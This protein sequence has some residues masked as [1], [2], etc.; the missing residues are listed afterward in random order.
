[1]I[2]NT[3]KVH[4]KI[5]APLKK[6]KQKKKKNMYLPTDEYFALDILCMFNAIKLLYCILYCILR[7]D[8]NNRLKTFK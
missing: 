3:K 4:I 8:C 7:H 5:Q 2:D 6:Q 1:M